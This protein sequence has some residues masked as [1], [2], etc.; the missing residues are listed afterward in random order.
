MTHCWFC[1]H[2]MIW[3]SD[4]SFDEL[5]Y[6]DDGV[7]AML[8]CPSCGAMAEFSIKEESPEL[9]DDAYSLPK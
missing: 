8:S 1:G 3:Q 5:G 4:Y 9:R 6:E 7:V 2:D